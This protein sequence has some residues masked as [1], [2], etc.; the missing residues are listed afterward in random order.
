MPTNA[1]DSLIADLNCDNPTRCR[2]ARQ[3]LVKK[4]EEAVPGLAASLKQGQD[5]VPLEA[6][7]A[8]GKIGGPRATKV[9]I[10]ALEDERS[11]VRWTAAEAL[12]NIGRKAVPPLLEALMKKGDSLEMRNGVHHVLSDMV[13]PKLKPIVAPVLAALEDAVP[14]LEAPVAADKALDGLK[15]A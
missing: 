10:E 4:G 7:K 2:Q 8:L 14:S 3:V 13:D 9:L 5:F 6:A 1:M 11:E 15:R 12:I